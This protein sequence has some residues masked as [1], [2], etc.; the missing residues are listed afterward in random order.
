M[1]EDTWSTRDVPVLR[2]VVELYEQ[3]GQAVQVGE[4]ARAT[5]FD[6]DTVQRAIRA[7]MRQPYFEKTQGAS[8]G[9]IMRVGAPTGDALRVVGQWPTPE[10]Q[11]DRLIAAF[12]AMAEDDSEPKERR[13]MAKQIGLWLSGAA[14]QVALDA[15]GGAGGNMLSG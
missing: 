8:G 2:A 3:T 12:E 7:L 9:Q 5:D 10:N 14:T 15:L 11:L 6:Q 13:S 4:I 1:T